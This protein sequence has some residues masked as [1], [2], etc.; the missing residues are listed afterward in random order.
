VCN[1]IDA[2]CPAGHEPARPPS[3]KPLLINNFVHGL[4]FA[5]N[6]GMKR[7]NEANLGQILTVLLFSAGQMLAGE[8][9]AQRRIIVSIPDHKLAL[10]EGGQVL[11]VFDVAVGKPSTPSPQ[12]EFKVVTRMANPTWYGPHRIVPPGKTN[13]LGTRWMGLSVKG[14]GIHGTSSPNSIGKSA[15]HGCIRM[16]NREVEELFEMVPVGTPVELTGSRPEL[17]QKLPAVAD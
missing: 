12:G 14:F 2:T 9:A 11:R 1:R 4:A 3:H 7:R 5:L 17:F 16:R 15:S 13:P 6:R 8:P 10:I